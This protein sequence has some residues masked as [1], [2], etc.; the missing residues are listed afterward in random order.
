MP[1]PLEQ[2]PER[3]KKEQLP[4]ELLSRWP[5][6][7]DTE[8]LELVYGA[9]L[10]K[11]VDQS[12]SGWLKEIRAQHPGNRQEA[13][14]HLAKVLRVSE[15]EV[16]SGEQDQNLTLRFFKV[17]SGLPEDKISKFYQLALQNKLP[18]DYWKNLKI[19]V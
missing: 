12:I 13:A 6:V 10:A 14:N 17:L 4:L 3:S 8:M 2:R 5:N 16:L 9:P 18:A 7:T 11:A 15:Q 19:K 1:H